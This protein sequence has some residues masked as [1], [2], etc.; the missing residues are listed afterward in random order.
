[1]ILGLSI[2]YKHDASYVQKKRL[3]HIRSV[4]AAIREASMFFSRIRLLIP[5]FMLSGAAWG[6]IITYLPLLLQ[7]RTTLSLTYIGVLV[8]VWVIVGGIAS[9]LYGR[10]HARIGRKK[11]LIG[12][13]FT[14]GIAGILLSITMSVMVF[15]VLLI[16]LGMTVFLTYPTLFSFVSEI[17]HES[18]EGQTFAFVFTL[19]LGG[20]TIL[21][22]LSG[23]LSDIVGVW[24]PFVLLGTLGLL[25]SLLYL[26]YY[27]HPYVT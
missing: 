8:S 19:Q 24:I 25:L 22:F 12:S 15:V 3:P 11:I 1:M 4:R 7:E 16:L 21:V 26:R 17:T 5:A 14:I 9:F 20:G 10:F 6:I 27:Q 13:Y 2:T 18:R 23:F